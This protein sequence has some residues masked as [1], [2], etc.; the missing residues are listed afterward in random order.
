[1]GIMFRY[2]DCGTEE[3][4]VERH[5]NGRNLSLLQIS[6]WIEKVGGALVMYFL[7]LESA[8][9]GDESCF[10]RVG[11]VVLHN[12]VD[13]EEWLGEWEVKTVLIM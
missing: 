13:V 11:V 8:D 4:Y 7:I 2:F 12:A 6:T 10:R 9:A 1:M 5:Q 3:R